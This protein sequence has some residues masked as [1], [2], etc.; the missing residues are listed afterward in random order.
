M[1]YDIR[2]PNMTSFPGLTKVNQ[3]LRDI[4]KQYVGRLFKILQ[5]KVESVPAFFANGTRKSHYLI[6]K[7]DGNF[8]SLALNVYKKKFV[9]PLKKL[10]VAATIPPPAE[11]LQSMFRT[12]DVL[13][14]A[15]RLFMPLPGKSLIASQTN[16][17]V[18]LLWRSC[19]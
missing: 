7:V 9:E 14:Q 1:V 15:S 2:E 17:F 11:T 16:I 12:T 18:K 13:T 5:A 8:E 19:R 4:P 6:G 10:S 3:F